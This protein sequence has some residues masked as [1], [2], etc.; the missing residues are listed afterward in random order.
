VQAESKDTVVRPQ[1]SWSKI[2]ITTQPL[3]E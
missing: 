1:W 3:P 2:S